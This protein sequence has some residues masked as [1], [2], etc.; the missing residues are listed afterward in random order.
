MH[1][2]RGLLLGLSLLLPALS[3]VGGL[4]AEGGL[5]A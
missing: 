2:F 3:F 4:T 5:R 1:Q